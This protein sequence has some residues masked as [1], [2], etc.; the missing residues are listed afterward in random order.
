MDKDGSVRYWRNPKHEERLGHDHAFMKQFIERT[1]AYFVMC[2]TN[3]IA[4]CYNSTDPSIPSP[5]HYIS[6]YY[7]YAWQCVKNIVMG[8]P[9]CLRKNNLLFMQ[10]TELFDRIRINDYLSKYNTLQHID[11]MIEE[12]NDENNIDA[13]VDHIDE[14][15]SRMKDEDYL[16]ELYLRKGRIYRDRKDGK[17]DYNLAAYWMR[18]ASDYKLESAF[19]ELFDVLWTIGTP[20]STEEM[21]CIAK[22]CSSEGNASMTGRMGRA[23]RDGRGV[24]KNLDAAAEWMLKSAKMGC[25]WAKVEYFD[26]LWE[27]NTPE[28]LKAMM[29]Y[30]QSES[31]KGNIVLRE[32]M[33]KAYI[34]VK[35]ADAHTPS[36]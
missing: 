36:V 11:E 32:R 15:I 26:I 31:E 30:A 7:E 29:E 2:P 23:Y 1:G 24:Q 25:D 4:D 20:E 35:G 16:P 10:T 19:D 33:A 28:S 22:K 13:V 27:M 6:E 5:L 17:E 12:T 21:L 14:I 18:E 9:D 8:D 34:E 3:V